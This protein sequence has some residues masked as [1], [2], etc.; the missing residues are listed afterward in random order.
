MSAADT[1]SRENEDLSQTISFLQ[2]SG[3]FNPKECRRTEAI[4]RTPLG[5]VNHFYC[6]N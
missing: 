2:D 1:C 5:T 3:F 6:T 4:S